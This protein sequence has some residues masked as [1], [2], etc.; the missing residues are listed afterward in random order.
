ML[1]RRSLKRMQTRGFFW[2]NNGG[3]G[4]AGEE[5]LRLALE[6]VTAQQA[7]LNDTVAEMKRRLARDTAVPSPREHASAVTP[8]QRAASARESPQPLNP[9][10]FRRF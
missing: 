7:K 1:L 3:A 10:P 8:E 6:A 4:G 2:G 5:K 9:T